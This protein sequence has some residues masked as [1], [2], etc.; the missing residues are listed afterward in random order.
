[1]SR[2]C[3]HT[4]FHV[5]F[6]PVGIGRTIET[7]L[8]VREV[9]AEEYHAHIDRAPRAENSSKLGAGRVCFGCPAVLYKYRGRLVHM[10]GPGLAS[11]FILQ[12]VTERLQGSAKKL[13]Q[14]VKRSSG[15]SNP[16]CSPGRCGAYTRG[17]LRKKIIVEED[18][19]R[20]G[21]SPEP[22]GQQHVED[23]ALTSDQGF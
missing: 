8:W 13:L 12:E 22:D 3:P 4:Q 7:R 1:M 23:L 19:R 21:R 20:H 2:C 9:F 10:L 18:L 17:R 6:L 15:L 11:K 5:L 14:G 16:K